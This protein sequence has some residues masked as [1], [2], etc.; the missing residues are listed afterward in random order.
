MDAIDP[1][2]ELAIGNLSVDLRDVDFSGVRRHVRARLGVG[3]LNVTVPTGVR[4]VLDAHAGA[5]GVTAF[6][7][8]AQECCPTD[9]HRV[10]SGSAGGGTLYLDAEVGAG[11]VDITRRQESL[12]ASS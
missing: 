2:Y 9:V 4:V 3:Q 12:R 7:R 1:E 5:G 8:S 6:G 10:S 11:H